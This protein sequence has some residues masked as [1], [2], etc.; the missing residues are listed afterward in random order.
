MIRPI[1][2]GLPLERESPPPRSPGPVPIWKWIPL[3]TI[4]IYPMIITGEELDGSSGTNPFASDSDSPLK[5]SGQLWTSYEFNDP[6]PDGS[7]DYNGPYHENTGFRINRAL[8]NMDYTWK[9]AGEFSGSYLRMTPAVLGSGLSNQGDLCESELNPDHPAVCEGSNNYAF[10]LRY[11]FGDFPVPFTDKK[12]RFRVGQQPAAVIASPV[13]DLTEAMGHRFIDGSPGGLMGASAAFLNLGYASSTERGISLYGKWKYGGFQIMASNGEGDSSNNAENISVFTDETA[14]DKLDDLATGAGD[15]YGMDVQGI[16]N[17]RPTGENRELQ[18]DISLPFLFKNVSGID[19]SEYKYTSVN[20]ACASGCDEMPRIRYY[21]GAAHA[22]QDIYAGLQADLAW[23]ASNDLSFKTGG[24]PMFFLD[25]R[26][27]SF[28]ITESSLNPEDFFAT[29]S[30]LDDYEAR[31]LLLGTNRRYEKDTLGKALYL[32]A[33]G[34]Y[35]GIGIFYQLTMGTGSGFASTDSEIQTGVSSAPSSVPW[36]VQAMQYDIA[37]DG[38]LGNTELEDIYLMQSAIDEGQARFTKNVLALTY[39]LTDHVRVAL[40]WVRIE[41]TDN[42]G[43]AL[44]TTS[45][46]HIYGDTTSSGLESKNLTT[47]VEEIYLPT[48]GIPEGV[49]LSD[50]VGKKRVESQTFLSMEM[51]F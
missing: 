6:S 3:L 7:G 51:T 50:L 35:R 1:K 42:R 19:S 14:S 28:L 27:E 38:Y 18:F 33:S 37:R 20:M 23:K 31:Q 47:Q 8:I 24:G 22:K 12:I 29:G 17:F 32:Y 46:D 5:I 2:K 49:L 25:R 34:E 16:L 43:V 9:E 45:F 21:Q 15:S 26:S 11:A 39:R 13:H 4:F 40:S 30:V 36:V 10:M 44:R 48:I 41:G